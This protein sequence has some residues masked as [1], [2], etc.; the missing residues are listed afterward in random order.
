MS[1]NTLWAR[2]EPQLKKDCAKAAI[3]ADMNLSEWVNGAMKARLAHPNHEIFVA[4]NVHI[5]DTIS[6]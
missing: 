1:S 2:I 6:V 5:W 4:Q 3:D